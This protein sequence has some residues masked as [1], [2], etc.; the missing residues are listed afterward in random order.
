M[1][2]NY[3]IKKT[4]GQT[5]VEELPGMIGLLAV[6]GLIYW[7][8]STVLSGPSREAERQLVELRNISMRIETR[9]E[10]SRRCKYDGP[11]RAK[12]R[13]LVRDTVAGTD[14]WQCLDGSTL[15]LPLARDY[16]SEHLLPLADLS[17]R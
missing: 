7:G 3:E 15:V 16:G 9:I 13:L 8:L 14:A 1:N 4:I 11:V 10:Q 5:I 17:G 12:V 6:G 2:K